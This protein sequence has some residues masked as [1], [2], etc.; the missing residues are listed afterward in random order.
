MNKIDMEDEF[1][2]KK[3]HRFRGLVKAKRNLPFI[4]RVQ[5]NFEDL[6][7]AKNG[8]LFYLEKAKTNP[9]RAPPRFC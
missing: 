1:S 8:P 3:N 5:S 6:P 7:D 4:R 2:A 9:G